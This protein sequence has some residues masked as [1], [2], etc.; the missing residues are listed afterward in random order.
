MA[1]RQKIYKIKKSIIAIPVAPKDTA[2][3]LKNECDHLEVF[4]K[5]SNFQSVGQFYKDFQPRDNDMVIKIL[6]NYKK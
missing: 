2:D 5:P 4:M 1:K 6:N 3:R